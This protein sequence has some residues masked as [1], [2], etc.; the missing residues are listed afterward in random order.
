[1][2]IDAYERLDAVAEPCGRDT[3][4]VPG[5][6]AT[7]LQPPHPLRDSGRAQPYAAAQLTEF[8]PAFGLKLVKNSPVHTVKTG[9]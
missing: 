3:C 4:R 1:M 9:Y 2:R 6:D 8:H 5:D 7:L